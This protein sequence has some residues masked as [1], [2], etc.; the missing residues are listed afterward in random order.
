MDEK[1]LSAAEALLAG[2]AFL[3]GRWEED[4]KKANEELEKVRQKYAPG[5]ELWKQTIKD[6]EKDLIKFMKGNKDGLFEGSDKVSLESGV[7]LYGKEIKVSLPR[8]VV[9]R[10]QEQGWED[11]IIQ[12]PT[13][14]RP[15]V[16][17]WP[18]ERLTVIGGGR[19][20]VEQFS[21]EL[22]EGR[23]KTQRAAGSK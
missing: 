20:E 11:G 1:I 8:D 21:Y 6:R 10:I 22:K 9:A 19:K 5:L 17:Q 18:D 12:T 3:S 23:Q 4:Q 7:L 14:N 16:E 13:L 15:V 2:I